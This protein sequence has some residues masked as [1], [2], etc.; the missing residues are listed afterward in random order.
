M[1]SFPGEEREVRRPATLQ[2]RALNPHPH[3]PLTPPPGPLTPPSWP[4]AAGEEEEAGVGCKRAEY[5]FGFD[6]V[7]GG[8]C[9][10]PWLQE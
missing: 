1:C 7:W 5:N 2:S 4:Q 6:L 3:H 9:H 10:L 8:G